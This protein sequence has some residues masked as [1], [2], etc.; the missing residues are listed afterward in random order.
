MLFQENSKKHLTTEVWIITYL[1]FLRATNFLEQI[2]IKLL[3]KMIA[4]PQ[5][6]FHACTLDE[7]SL[8][9][10]RVNVIEI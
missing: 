10:G 8:S 7:S 5:N 4:R 2:R 1:Y 3:I 9:I 6:Y